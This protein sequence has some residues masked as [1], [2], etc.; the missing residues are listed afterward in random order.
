M[1]T[2]EDCMFF[3]KTVRE[4][5]EKI[6]PNERNLP[7]AIP[8]VG[9]ALAVADK[10]SAFIVEAEQSSP[11]QPA[12]TTIRDRGKALDEVVMKLVASPG[13][14][15]VAYSDILEKHG[16]THAI[17]K[18]GREVLESMCELLKTDPAHDEL[19]QELQAEME[20]LDAI[21]PFSQGKGHNTF[22]HSGS[23][24][25]FNNTGSGPQ[26]NNSANGTQWN[27]SSIGSFTPPK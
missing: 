15:A 4:N 21:P 20:K 6:D 18:L 25:Q 23:G 19:V 8:V 16:N 12:L 1:S 3:T 5:V 7:P 26:N 9:E 11:N 14:V 10:G 2:N 22:N 17:E 13:S 27:I 24:P